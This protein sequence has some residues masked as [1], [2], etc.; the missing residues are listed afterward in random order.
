MPSNQRNKLSFPI[1][2]YTQHHFSEDAHGVMIIIIGNGHS[3]FSS[4][5]GQGCLHFTKS[6]EKGM[7]TT[8]LFPYIVGQTGLFNLGTATSVGEGKH[9]I[10]T[11]YTLLKNWPCVASCV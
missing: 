5:F 9:W 4:N 3:N 2:S 8:C 6:L 10:Q 11:C 7:N 1:L